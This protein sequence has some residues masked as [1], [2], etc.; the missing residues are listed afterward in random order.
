MSF[1][2]MMLFCCVGIIFFVSAYS[3]FGYCADTDKRSR[4][5]SIEGTVLSINKETLFIDGKEYPLS[6][7]VRVFI[8]SESGWNVTLNT[9]TDVGHIDK[10][11]IY[12]ERGLVDR[13]IVLEVQQ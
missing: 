9:I 1:R 2:K 10:A 3:H 8:G 11:R 13:I 6:G 5:G 12:L 4:D 7:S